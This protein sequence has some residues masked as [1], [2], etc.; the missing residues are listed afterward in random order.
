MITDEAVELKL[1]MDKFPPELT[2]TKPEPGLNSKLSGA[3]N[4]IDLGLVPSDEKS[5]RRFS[6]ITILL[7]GW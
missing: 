2:T 7:R 1:T 3:V 5:S 6:L 4:S